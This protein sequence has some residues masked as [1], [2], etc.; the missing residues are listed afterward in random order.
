[1]LYDDF[2]VLSFTTNTKHHDMLGAAEIWHRGFN[3]LLGNILEEIGIMLPRKV[4]YA[5][6]SNHFC[7]TSKIYKAYVND[8][9][10]PA[11]NIMDNHPSIRRLCWQDSKYSQLIDEPLSESAK[12]K[13][14][15]SYYPMFPF[16]LERLFS[17]WI[18]DK[19]L[20][21]KTI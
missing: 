5:I 13:L 2:D 14:G 9:L 16:I 6:Y 7:A 21:V 11:M 3:E 1:M 8:C 19:E 20:N 4:K 12:E 17:V 10:I 15:I 18:N